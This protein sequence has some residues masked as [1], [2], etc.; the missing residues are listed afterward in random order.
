MIAAD[1]LCPCRAR[2]RQAS[3]ARAETR[4]PSAASRGYGSKWAAA[5]KDFLAM[6]PRCVRCDAAASVVDHIT[7]HR[8]GHAKTEAERTTSL[9]TF[10]RRSNWQ[11]LC[12]RCHD[13]AKQAEERGN[14]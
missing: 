12:R 13:S 10:W 5:R 2:Q 4:R 1:V 14:V 6:H 7:P 3:K 8:L 9:K 11:S